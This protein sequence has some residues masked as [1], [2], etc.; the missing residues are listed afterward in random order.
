[1]DVP[2]AMGFLTEPGMFEP[3]ETW[4]HWLCEVQAWEDSPLK[5]YAIHSA[6]KTITWKRL[7]LAAG[8]IL[9]ITLYQSLQYD[10]YVLFFESLITFDTMSKYS[11]GIDGT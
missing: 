4:E 11:K 1:M 8:I 9:E 2:L 7:Y 3:I 6:K 5:E 10:W